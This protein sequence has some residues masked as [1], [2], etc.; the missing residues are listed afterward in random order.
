MIR[1]LKLRA[2]LARNRSP[3]SP[4][5]QRRHLWRFLPARD[6]LRFMHHVC[7]IWVCP[8]DQPVELLGLLMI[9]LK[10]R[11]ETVRLLGAIDLQA[12]QGG[13]YRS[14][15]PDLCMS[16]EAGMCRPTTC[17]SGGSSADVS[18]TLPCGP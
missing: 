16:D 5:G 13:Y 15:V 2:D 8:Y 14:E 3:R 18:L 7:G 1:R 11:R 6:R 12:A 17:T 4:R 9:K 10:L